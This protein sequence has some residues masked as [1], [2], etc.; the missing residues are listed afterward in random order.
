VAKVADQRPCRASLTTTSVTA[1][2]EAD[3]RSCVGTEFCQQLSAL[4]PGREAGDELALKALD[5]PADIALG[6]AIFVAVCPFGLTI[7][8]Q[9]Y[10]AVRGFV[11]LRGRVARCHGQSVLVWDHRLLLQIGIGGRMGGGFL[12]Q[13]WW[14]NANSILDSG[15]PTCYGHRRLG[16][17]L[18]G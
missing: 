3:R 5:A 2:R 10:A 9:G 11:V 4:A 18:V 7:V 6:R 13:T 14:N 17:W 8:G 12:P 16:A 15:L 1:S